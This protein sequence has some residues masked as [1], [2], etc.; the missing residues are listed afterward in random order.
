MWSAEVDTASEKMKLQWSFTTSEEEGRAECITGGHRT[1]MPLEP[2]I[3]GG[4]SLEP[5]VMPLD[6]ETVQ[7][8][9]K[10]EKGSGREWVTIKV[11]AAPG[12]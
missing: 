2:S 5:L 7:V 1:R 9:G 8:T 12:K 3:F 4:Q 10:E 6:S 11:V